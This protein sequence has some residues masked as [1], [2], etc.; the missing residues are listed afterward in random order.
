MVIV[1]VPDEVVG[2]TRRI[3][4]NTPELHT[5]HSTT[6]GLSQSICPTLLVLLLFVISTSYSG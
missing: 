6:V 4:C 3:K 2:V 1:L 5:V